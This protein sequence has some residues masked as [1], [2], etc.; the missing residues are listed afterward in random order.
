MES[1][2]VNHFHVTNGSE[3]IRLKILDLGSGPGIISLE[4]AKRYPNC[5]IF[6]I[7]ISEN[8]I[9]YAQIEAKKHNLSKNTKFYVGSAENVCSILGPQHFNSFDMVICGQCWYVIHYTSLQTL[10]I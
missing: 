5:K 3:N 6:G 2:L 1:Y 9:K 4:L 8:Q 10:R 7:D